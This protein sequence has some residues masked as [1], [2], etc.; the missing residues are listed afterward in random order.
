[1]QRPIRILSA[2][3]VVLSPLALAQTP[4][5]LELFEKNV[6]PVFVE[7]C[8]SCHNTK[9]K[10]GGLDFSTAEGIKEASL[11]GIFGSE[12]DPDKS[13]VIEA[14]GYESR[15]KM[16]PQ[17]KLPAE[18][19]AG[20][21]EWV[22]AGAAVP[23]PPKGA[24]VSTTGLR[25]I[26][27]RGKITDADKNFWAFKPN[28]HPEP[29]AADRKDWS[30]N[31]IDRFVLANLEKHDLKPA[32]PASKLTLIRRATYD[33]IGLPPSEKE[34]NDFLADQSP[35]AFEKVVDR[36]LASPRYG[37]HWG[38][39]WLDTM[40]YADST[41]SDEDHRYPHAWRYRDYVIKAFN[42]D[43]PYNQF[44]REQ[45]A[46]DILAADPNSGV[47]YRGYVAT[48]FLA[49]GKKALAQKDLPLKRYDV[50]D[51][52]I[53]VT[54][55]ALLGL[56]VTC[57]RCH[58]HKF[59]PIATKDYYA[60]AAIFASTLSYEK[61]EDGD[62]VQTP[63]AAPGE[64]EAFRKQWSAYLKNEREIDKILDFDK[65]AQKERTK[66]EEQ[67]PAY[68]MAAET[69]RADASLDSAQLAK[70]AA[71]LKSGAPELAKWRAAT[72]A[73]REQIAKQYQEDFHR[74]AY[75]YDQNLSW[76]KGARG[77]YPAAGKVA[78]PRP[79]VDRKEDPFFYALWIDSKGPL[80]RSEDERIAA[81]PADK[82]ESIRKLIAGR[83]EMEKTLPAREIPMAQAVKE[84]PVME[85][86]VFLRGDY[87]NPGDPVTQTMPAIL[88]LSAPAPAVTQGSGRL[89]L[90]NWVVDPKN[91][92]PARVM[93][94]RIWQGHFGDGIVRTPDNFGRLGDRP[95]NP[96]LLDYLAAQFV[97]NGWS[98]KK[99]HKAIMLSKTYQMSA[100]YDE[101]TKLKDTDNRFLSHFPR[102]RLSI[103]EIRD[104]YLAIGRDLDLTMGGTLD[105]GVGT[106]GETSSS[107]IS[108]NPESTNRRSIYLPLRRS[109][110]PTL[111]MLFD[112]GDATS[113]EG[114]RNPTTVATQ[115]L[116]VMNSPMVN[117]EAKNLA[118]RL[119]KENAKDSKRIEEAYVAILDR[120]PDAGEIDAGLT[121]MQSLRHKW[122]G[123]DEA[124][125]WQS[126]C[127]ALMASNEFMYI[128]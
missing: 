70:W 20:V 31:A 82:A 46:G 13:I 30:A 103:E 25:P 105:P 23:E 72:D 58:D 84:G 17:G 67:I 112:F 75:Q 36:L 86:H 71:Y 64:F 120:K 45:L 69:G 77:S 92:L 54:S 4:A 8:R 16:P 91:P 48:G 2:I 11:N 43:M 96:E 7:K 51:D 73:N 90:A 123:I 121:Y 21:R 10:S 65:V 116:F 66:A 19:I 106:D 124:K 87:H 42:D 68:M 113:P 88:R 94:N 9:L 98:V 76:W 1:M 114:K 126:F 39:L 79:T 80:Y 83:A 122:N 6:R 53:D 93:V 12:N 89:E 50:V 74:S 38:R 47:G 115:A 59:D 111:Y 26:A 37:E 35:N 127:H 52:Q 41:G 85:Q 18:T 108:M 63:L 56:T 14:L 28:A 57:A 15:V 55:K 3:S 95:S 101:A 102:Q 22:A 33:L 44:V 81:L 29:P 78:G 27:I 60:M 125:S 99:M 32:A 61:G 117:R 100:V 34:I 118:D 49:L 109:N 97:E 24:E 128:Y 119:M 62:P 5:Q 104:S 107:R 110:L 40:R